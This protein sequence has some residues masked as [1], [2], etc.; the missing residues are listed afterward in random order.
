VGVG[1]REGNGGIVGPGGTGGSDGTAGVGGKG[2]NGGIV[3]A[4][5]KGGNAGAVGVI[6]NGGKD[7]TANGDRGDGLGVW[8][9]AVTIR[10]A[11]NSAVA[12]ASLISMSAILNYRSPSS[13]EILHQDRR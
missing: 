1:G 7:G 8:A 9:N 3:G 12:P 13:R 4:G 11:V 5:D 2:G 10:A 6:G